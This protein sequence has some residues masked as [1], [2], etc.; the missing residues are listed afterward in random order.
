[1]L[2]VDPLGMSPREQLVRGFQ[3]L[4]LCVIWKKCKANLELKKDITH[5]FK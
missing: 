2:E 4:N 3:D 1:M 5:L